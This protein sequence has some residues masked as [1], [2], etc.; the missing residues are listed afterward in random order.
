[1]ERAKEAIRNDRETVPNTSGSRCSRDGPHWAR[2]SQ[3]GRV[4]S[5]ASFSLRKSSVP[6]RNS[7]VRISADSGR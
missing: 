1:M 7:R 5:S 3:R 6:L 4:A 2:R